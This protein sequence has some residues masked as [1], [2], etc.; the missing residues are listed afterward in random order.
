MLFAPAESAYVGLLTQRLGLPGLSIDQRVDIWDRIVG[1]VF[2][3]L[4]PRTSPDLRLMVELVGRVPLP[5]DPQVESMIRLSE[6]KLALERQVDL[7]SMRHEREAARE[8]VR[9]AASQPAVWEDEA[10]PEEEPG[11]LARFCKPTLAD[12]LRAFEHDQLDPIEAEYFR[13]QT[14]VE[15]ARLAKAH[16][17]IAP[18]D[19]KP[20]RFRVVDSDLPQRVKLDVLRRLDT[21]GRGLP[22]NT[23]AP[24]DVKLHQWVEAALELPLGKYKPMGVDPDDPV[25]VSTLVA[26]ARA[27]MDAV[28][29][30]QD[31]A[32]DS[33]LEVMAAYVSSSRSGGGAVIGLHGKPG[34]GKTSLLRDGVAPALGLPIGFINLSGSVESVVGFAFT[35]ESSRYGSIS[36]TLMRGGCMNPILVLD[37]ADKCGDDSPRGQEMMNLLSVLTDSSA[38]PFTDRY[39]AGIDLPLKDALIVLTYNDPS[40][41]SDILRDRIIEIEMDSFSPAAQTE[42]ASSYTAPTLMRELAIPESSVQFAPHALEHL[43]QRYTD[44]KQ[45]GMRPVR[46]VLQRLLMRLNLLF[47]TRAVES[48]RATGK[49]PAIRAVLL[50]LGQGGPVT[51]DAALIDELLK[52][53]VNPRAADC[54]MFM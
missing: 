51:V 5:L 19:G 47:R 8:A 9:E 22:P 29:S 12:E 33:L 27:R 45:G 14:G 32:K 53:T 38:A 39:F 31:R 13:R 20:L 1:I 17:D 50:T 49:V 2:E 24:A 35:F 10:R 48:V 15:R 21:A 40:R 28:V 42:I 26:D 43:A 34:T 54:G 4:G 44:N 7:A 36:E 6:A 52:P 41:L 25:Q 11:G 16:G 46:K 37:E 3:H 23:I 30:G 18:V